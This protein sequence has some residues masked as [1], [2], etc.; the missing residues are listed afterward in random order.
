MRVLR[1]LPVGCL[2]NSQR[3]L[4]PMLQQPDLIIG[5]NNALSPVLGFHHGW[6][7]RCV[8]TKPVIGHSKRYRQVFEAFQHILIRLN[9][10]GHNVDLVFGKPEYIGQL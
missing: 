3:M 5:K 1:H 2:I 4:K 10:A 9:T 7:V 6:I 8:V